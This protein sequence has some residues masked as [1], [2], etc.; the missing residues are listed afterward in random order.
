[1]DGIPRMLMTYAV[2]QKI[3]IPSCWCLLL[4]TINALSRTE[5]TRSIYDCQLVGPI[6]QKSCDCINEEF[7]RHLDDTIQQTRKVSAYNEFSYGIDKLRIRQPFILR[8]FMLRYCAENDKTAV[9]LIY[10]AFVRYK[11][12]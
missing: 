1:M 3:F 7:E 12:F 11:S 5:S 8:N 6:S 9:L 4:S 10:Q 2:A